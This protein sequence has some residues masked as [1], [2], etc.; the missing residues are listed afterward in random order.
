MVSPAVEECVDGEHFFVEGP[1]AMHRLPEVR[2]ALGS[3]PKAQVLLVRVPA[4][5]RAPPEA[6]AKLTHGSGRVPSTMYDRTVQ[7]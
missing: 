4:P 5:H 7:T 3:V 1:V 6:A 2:C